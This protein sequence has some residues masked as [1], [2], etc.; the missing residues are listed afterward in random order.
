MRQVLGAV[1][2]LEDP[3]SRHVGRK[4]RYVSAWTREALDEAQPHGIEHDHEYNRNGNS[5]EFKGYGCLRP[6]RQ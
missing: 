6:G 3:I 4:T 1:A 5:C 2:Q